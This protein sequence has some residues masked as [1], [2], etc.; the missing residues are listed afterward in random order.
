MSQE[1]RLR[2]A[3]RDPDRGCCGS[4]L[5]QLP[6]N[7]GARCSHRDAAGLGGAVSAAAAVRS[8]A[9]SL[10]G[11]S[12]ALPAPE[13]RGRH[14]QRP[15]PASAPPASREQ[16][17]RARAPTAG[18]VM[19]AAP[20]L[21]AALRGPGAERT[22]GRAGRLRASRRAAGAGRGARAPTLTPA[23]PRRG[24]ARAQVTNLTVSPLG[25]AVTSKLRRKA[26]LPQS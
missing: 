18:V 14:A 5:G 9:C 17:R 24:H 4:R 6:P 23:A 10:A 16:P 11:E 19:A 15:P 12:E 1:E 21:T 3:S 2:Q 26:K 13:P 7:P 8:L 25:R 20:S 22:G